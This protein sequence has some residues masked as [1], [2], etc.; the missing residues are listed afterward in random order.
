MQC[1]DT[2]ACRPTTN[3]LFQFHL[4][5]RWG[6]DVQASLNIA[7]MLILINKQITKWCVGKFNWCR[8]YTGRV[9]DYRLRL[10]NSLSDW[11]DV[12]FNLY[13]VKKS[14]ILTQLSTRPIFVLL[15]FWIAAVYLKFETKVSS[16]N[17]C[18]ISLPNVV[19]YGPLN[20]ENERSKLCNLWE[21][22]SK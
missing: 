3:R 19:H 13:G 8:L 20:I 14:V 11:T 21:V 2:E 18:P 12:S 4:E 1:S 22:R 9:L 6:M 7:Y 5:D 15:L 16:N 10:V 17:N